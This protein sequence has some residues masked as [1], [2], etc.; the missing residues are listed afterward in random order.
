MTKTTEVATGV[1]VGGVVWIVLSVLLSFIPILGWAI[2]AI[3]GGYLAGRTGGAMA[4]A[5]LA[6]L[7]PLLTA[8]TASIFLS[9]IPNVLGMILGGA[10]GMLI[11]LWAL[12]N[13]IFVG[14]GGII[15]KGEYKS[16]VCPH[17]GERISEVVTVCPLCKKPVGV[18]KITNS[19]SRCGTTV[20]HGQRFCSNCGFLRHGSSLQTPVVNSNTPKFCVNCGAKI[21]VTAQFCGSCGA[22]QN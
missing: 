3:A 15:G 18:P 21:P 7:A 10:I 20:D 13:L 22:K 19:C 11:G 14:L 16:A 12:I 17:C 2:A 4:A 9:L 1:L 6:L 8:L 5:I